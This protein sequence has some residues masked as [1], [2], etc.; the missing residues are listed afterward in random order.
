VRARRAPLASLLAALALVPAGCGPTD[1]LETRGEDAEPVRL[2]TILPSPDD[3]RGPPAQA[4]GA[5]RLAAALT[6]RPDPAVARRITDRGMR[7]AAVRSWRSPSGGA[8]VATVS[9]WRS[10]LIAQG[11][12]TDAATGL[13][14][15]PGA[16]AWQP[17]E[18]RGS[19]GA[20]VDVPGRRELR[21]AYSVGPNAFTVRATGDVAEDVPVRTL[22]R[23]IDVLDAGVADAAP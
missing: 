17:A 6:G 15:A 22:R 20:R 12:G 21:L 2:L 3:L 23:M 4:V 16:E 1:T 7:A 5:E 10:H 9:V 14:D 19:R 13:L 8:L 18:V 11:V